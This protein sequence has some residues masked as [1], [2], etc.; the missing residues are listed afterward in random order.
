MDNSQTPKK[1]VKITDKTTNLHH[2]DT[3]IKLA[4][5]VHSNPGPIVRAGRT[6]IK[7][8]TN[9]VHLIQIILLL[10]IVINQIHNRDKSRTIQDQQTQNMGYSSVL[11]GLNKWKKQSKLLTLQRKNQ[12]YYCII[13]LLSGDIHPNPGPINHQGNVC[14]KCKKEDKNKH[15]VTCDT[16][17]HWSHINCTEENQCNIEKMLEESFQWICPNPICS[18]NHYIGKKSFTGN[19][20]IKYTSPSPTKAKEPR[21][22]TI[23]LN[24]QKNK[25]HNTNRYEISDIPAEEIYKVIQ[26]KCPKPKVQNDLLHE[27]TKIS[28]KEYQG[29]DLCKACKE[30]IKGTQ[31]ALTCDLCDRWIHQ[32]CSDMNDKIYNANRKK[33]HFPW[34]CNI[35][36]VD[37]CIIDA[38]A[39]ITLL[40][41]EEIPESLEMLKSSLISM[42]E[43]LILIMNSRSI[44]NKTEELEH[45]CEELKPDIICITETWLDD[46]VPTNFCTPTGYKTIRKDRS[47]EYKQKYGRNKG[48]GIAIYYKEHLIVEKNDYLSDE[49][50]EILWVQV[51]GKNSFMLGIV[52]RAEYTDLITEQ[53]GECKLEENIRKA[54]EITN[55]LILTGDLNID[56]NS[57][58]IKSTHL[59]EIYKCYGLSQYIKKPTRV[60][61]KSGKPTIIDHIWSNK[62][63]NLIKTTGTFTG[64]SDHFGTYMKLNLQHRTTDKDKIRYRCFKKYNA[65][66]YNNDINTKLL[67]SNINKYLE[68]NDV[69]RSAD[70]LIKIMQE[71][72]D[73]HAPEK[74]VTIGK[75]KSKTKW[76]TEELKDK[77]TEKN[78]LLTDYFM[79]GVQSLKDRANKLKNEINHIKRKFKKIY[80][81]DKIKEAD[82][83]TKKLWKILK[84]VTG[85][86]KNKE[87]VEPEMMTQEKANKHNKFFATVGV[88]IQK[89]LVV[90][91]HTTDFTKLQGFMF[92]EETTETVSKLID[93]IRTD[94]AVG[95]DK[96]SAKLIKDCKTVIAPHIAKIINIGYKT[97]TFPT[98]MKT[99][100]IKPIHKKKCVDDITNYRPISILPTLSKVFERAATNQM[101]SYL[102]SNNK[103]NKNQHAYRSKHSTVTCLVEVLN[104]IYKLV[105][106]KMCTAIASLDLSKAFDSISHTLLLYKLSKLGMGESCLKWI[107]SYLKDRK[108]KTKF[109][110]YL[111]SEETVESGIPQGSII[112]PLLFICFTND[113]ADEFTDCKM[114]SYADDTQLIVDAENMSKLKLKIENVIKTAQKWYESN[115][116]KNNIG[117]TEILII[118]SSKNKNRV[119]IKVL[120]EGKYVTIEN[121]DSIE[122]LG[123]V[124]DQCLNWK[125]QVNAVKRKSMNRIRNLNRINHLLPIKYRT[126]LYQSLVEP[127]FSYADVAWGGCGVTNAKNLQIAQN[128]AARSILGMK[129]SASATMALHKLKFL[130]LQQRRTVHETVFTHKSLLNKHPDNINSIYQQHLPTGNTRG[131]ASGKLNIP[132]HKTAKFEHSPL[133][134]TIKTWNAVP[135]HIEKGDIRKHKAAYQRLLINSNL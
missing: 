68:N 33:R 57:P 131:A 26:R 77:I 122:I 97:S 47:N 101:V 104:Y 20:L 43:M 71:T 64:V 96:I 89:Q 94:V 74:E 127:L 95:S 86:G 62:E 52:Y 54:S 93:R 46:S 85:T 9:H 63:V 18:P 40:K 1:L 29:K 117:K 51:K 110:S 135:S 48:G 36:R 35:C 4:G 70:E 92:E 90:Q 75:E 42:K 6:K 22:K 58:A 105:D 111:S 119:K 72:A 87:N 99:T 8:T 84:E 107:K 82:G 30:Q 123:V 15:I 38:K 81:T 7:S 88:E 109:K 129:K 45:I 67:N 13:L 98:C 10:I 17:K 118:N 106:Q 120:D 91:T 128:F 125:K 133:F 114:V 60:D 11:I 80:Y 134:R 21:K 31:R 14:L 56:V 78:E 113:L 130:N 12:K 5:D 27:L 19:G 37:D 100:V 112:G 121:K 61:P 76:F 25:S 34:V 53:P 39:D 16:C 126:Q 3:V 44:V 49:I 32:K 132:K 23:L 50:E 103:I 102:E 59:K 69:N 2:K 79:S 66:D 83:D 28:A 65:S 55:R 116:M 124:L 24:V 108:Q 41:A 115:S 73:I